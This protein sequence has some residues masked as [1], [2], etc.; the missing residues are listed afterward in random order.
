MK[1]SASPTYPACADS[2]D[3][4]ARWG[5][6]GSKLS[7][8]PWAVVCVGAMERPPGSRMGFIARNTPG[9]ASQDSMISG[10]GP[11]R[12]LAQRHFRRAVIVTRPVDHGG[13]R[14]S[15]ILLDGLDLS[16]LSV[17]PGGPVLRA[18][19]ACAPLRRAQGP[20][21]RLF[22]AGRAPALTVLRGARGRGP[23]LVAL[24]RSIF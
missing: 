8:A 23:Y 24:L 3:G 12:L 11:Q 10:D 1:S 18:D 2:T 20:R 16:C 6:S 5:W 14:L 9:P 17:R 7:R 22:V 4:L 13:A 19:S 15:S 21:P